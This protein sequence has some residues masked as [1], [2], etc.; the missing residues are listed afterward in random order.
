MSLET[1]YEP[2]AECHADKSESGKDSGHQS[3]NRNSDNGNSNINRTGK[4]WSNEPSNK[5]SE[6][7]ALSYGKSIIGSNLID[8]EESKE[9]NKT[10]IVDQLSSKEETKEIEN[11]H[12]K[13]HLP[14]RF[15][16]R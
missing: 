7:V 16:K 10:S 8:K 13:V 2:N 6:P 11:S 4:N 3:N 5:N 9:H 15:S 14:E 12:S 1:A